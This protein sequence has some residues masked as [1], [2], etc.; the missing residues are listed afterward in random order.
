[1][2]TSD[3]KGKET[4]EGGENPDESPPPSSR[5]IRVKSERLRNVRKRKETDE[6]EEVAVVD[7]GSSATQK[8]KLSDDPGAGR[9]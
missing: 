8:K 3:T 1:V 5:G 6:D 9:R 2:S 7:E 4:C